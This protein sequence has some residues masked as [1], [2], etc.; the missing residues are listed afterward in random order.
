LEAAAFRHADNSIAVVILNRSEK[1][2]PFSLK[3]EGAG[4]PLTSLPH[5]ALFV[6]ID[7]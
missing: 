2:L 3:L 7:K 6:K 1:E 5:S 4:A